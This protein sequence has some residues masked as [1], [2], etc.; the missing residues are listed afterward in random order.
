MASKLE[1]Q[2]KALIINFKGVGNGFVALPILKCIEES[3]FKL[4]YYHTENPVLQNRWFIRKAGLRHLLGFIPAGWRR[5]K[6]QNWRDINNFIKTKNI[7]IVINFRNEGPEYD[8][9]YYQFK[10]QAGTDLEFWDLDFENMRSRKHQ[11]L[12]AR[13]ILSMLAK[14]N[15]D[16]SNYDPKWLKIIFEIGKKDSAQNKRIGF[17][18]A[19]AQIN[20][21]WPS[22][23]WQKLG[24]LLLEKES[25][26][27]IEVYGGLNEDEKLIAREV[28]E[29]LW[30]SYPKN[31]CL[32]IE[33]KTLISLAKNFSSLDLLISNDTFAI[34]LAT[35]LDIPAI[36]LYFQTDPDI[37]GGDSYKFIPIRLNN[38]FRCSLMKSTAGNCVHYYDNCPMASYNGRII[39]PERVFKII[40]F[41]EVNQVTAEQHITAEK[42]MEAIKQS[43]FKLTS[44]VFSRK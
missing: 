37:W 11:K 25:D 30:S 2:K 9:D 24:K 42:I 13:D 15:I 35:A 34:H 39:S 7:G 4:L 38:K 26:N 27:V 44:E 22:Y 12:L 18:T 41:T 23:N 3:A 32:L 10:Q 19:A 28:A 21:R 1:M 20:K 43:F 40:Q 29:Y 33:N 36:G 6:K 8:K 16:I 31:L 17:F 5:F 14:H